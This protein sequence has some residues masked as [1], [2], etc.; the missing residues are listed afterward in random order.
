MT[1]NE[2]SIRVGTSSTPNLIFI[3]FKGLDEKYTRVVVSD[4]YGSRFT[5]TFMKEKVRGNLKVVR[6]YSNKAIP[7]SFMFSSKKYWNTTILDSR[8]QRRRDISVVSQYIDGD[9]YVVEFEIPKD[10]S[11][12]INSS[13]IKKNI[14]PIPKPS[15]EIKSSVITNVGDRIMEFSYQQLVD[16]ISKW[17]SNPSSKNW[18]IQN[19][20]NILIIT[21]K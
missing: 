15:N 3:Y 13:R 11:T 21:D 4:L 6:Q 14:K 9:N 18:V 5:A 10:I 17:E 8:R 7:C 16:S 19:G 20:N 1:I 12:L 2:T